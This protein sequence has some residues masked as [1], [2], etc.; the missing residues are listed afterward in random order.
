MEALHTTTRC[1]A[2]LVARWR[3]RGLG[4]VDK[5]LDKRGPMDR[6]Q[7][8]EGIGTLEGRRNLKDGMREVTM[9]TVEVGP[10]VFEFDPRTADW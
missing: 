9:T 6:V 4:P 1:V 8:Q 5:Q 10:Y 3:S 7:V 2:S